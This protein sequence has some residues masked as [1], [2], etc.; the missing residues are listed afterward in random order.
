MSDR[1]LTEV[2]LLNKDPAPKSAS[3]A[4]SHSIEVLIKVKLTFNLS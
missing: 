3:K 1:I 2:Y 4:M